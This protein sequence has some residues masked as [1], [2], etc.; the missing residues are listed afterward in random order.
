MVTAFYLVS[1]FKIG[2]EY[3]QNNIHASVIS[4]DMARLLANKFKFHILQ[5]TLNPDRDPSIPSPN[6]YDYEMQIS[7]SEVQNS[8]NY[9]EKLLRDCCKSSL[10]IYLRSGK[11]LED[12]KAEVVK[13][14]TERE[15]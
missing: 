1:L 4:D 10:S 5:K 9:Y 6:N 8:L 15:D 12:L 13:V 3:S 14:I 7:L 11:S 2:L